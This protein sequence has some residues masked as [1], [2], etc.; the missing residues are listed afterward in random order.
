MSDA[1]KDFGRVDVVVANAGTGTS[2][3][4]SSRESVPDRS[5][6][7]LLGEINGALFLRIAEVAIDAIDGK[8]QRVLLK[9][10]MQKTS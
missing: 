8:S 1:A 6:R 3:D 7:N 9:V 2:P 5:P 10:C 4:T